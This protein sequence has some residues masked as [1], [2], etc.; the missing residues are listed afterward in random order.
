MVEER[1]TKTRTILYPPKRGGA[2]CPK[3][4]HTIGCNFDPCINKNFTEATKPDVK[5]KTGVTHVQISK[6]GY[7]QVQE[8]EVYD[9]NGKINLKGGSASQSSTYYW[10]FAPAKRVMDGDKKDYNRWWMSWRQGNSAHTLGGLDQWVR[11]KLPKKKD[12]SNLWDVTKVVVYGR[13][14]CSWGN[15]GLKGA[16]IQLWNMNVKPAKLIEEQMMNDDRRQAYYFGAKDSYYCRKDSGWCESKVLKVGDTNALKKFSDKCKK[17]GG[18]TGKGTCLEANFEK[19]KAYPKGGDC[20]WYGFKWHGWGSRFWPVSKCADICS[21][22]PNCNRFTFGA[23]NL[24]GGWGRCRT[25]T[26]YNSGYC[27]ITTD[28]YKSNNWRWWGSSNFWGGQVYDKKGKVPKKDMQYIGDFQDCGDNWWMNKYALSKD[29]DHHMEI[30]LLK[31]TVKEQLQI[32]K[33]VEDGEE[34]YRYIDGERHIGVQEMMQEYVNGD[35]EIINTLAY[36]GMVNVSVGIHLV[37]FSNIMKEIQRMRVEEKVMYGEDN[38]FQEEL[39]G[40]GLIMVVV[41]TA[42]MLDLRQIQKLLA[43]NKFGRPNPQPKDGTYGRGQVDEM[44]E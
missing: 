37:D 36:N 6:T 3:L 28:R 31:T 44:C 25:S 34:I 20:D 30:N 4:T 8:I 42:F 18:K 22:D 23:T 5:G 15:C 43:D 33:C 26:S 11:V 35:V 16:K 2:P 14:D 21:K 9:K 24:Y 10:W 13:A 12:G 40:G 29:G 27:P 39:I 7:V 32:V 17:D 38:H 19:S 41:E 1:K